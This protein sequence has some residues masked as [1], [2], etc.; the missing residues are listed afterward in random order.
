L[1]ELYDKPSV[2]YYGASCKA[3]SEHTEYDG[4]K[5]DREIG[6]EVVGFVIGGGFFV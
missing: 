4:G 3:I 6:I 5:V 2:G 1:Y